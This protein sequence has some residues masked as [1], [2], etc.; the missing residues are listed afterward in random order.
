M[1]D[2]VAGRDL[3]REQADAVMEALMTG[4]V[5]PAQVGGLLVALR[6]KGETVAEV[7]AA[8]QAMRRHVTRIHPAHRPLIDTCGTGGDRSGTFNISTTVAFV[9]AASGIH[10]AKHGNRAA[11]SRSGSADVLLALGVNVEA[12]PAVVERCIDD[13]GIGFLFAP[14]LHP[15]MKHVIGPRR[16]LKIRTLFNFLG[17]LTNP[18]FAEYQLIGVPDPAW[19]KRLATVLGEVG[20][21]RAFVV[22]GLDGLDEVTLC[23]RTAVAE[24]RD[25][26]ITTSIFDPEDLGLG[27]VASAELAGGDPEQNATILR[28]ILDGGAGPKRDVVCVNAAFALVA[29]GKAQA[30]Q[31]GLALAGELID[32]G[33]AKDRLDA[34]VRVSNEPA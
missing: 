15:A 6:M 27:R 17:P 25:G 11:S 2:L 7:T 18:A 1:N 31:A 5:T 20:V 19:T 10:V 22:A 12:V 23:E 9:V 21:E 30:L 28:E 33:A 24:L 4:Q 32:S 29:A 3:P 26:A 34:L 16:E 8:A 13:A 14:K